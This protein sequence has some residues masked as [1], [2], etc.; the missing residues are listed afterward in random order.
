MHI[1]VIVLSLRANV[2]IQVVVKMHNTFENHSS[3]HREAIFLQLSLDTLP[4]W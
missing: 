4:I 1:N 2:C 3:I